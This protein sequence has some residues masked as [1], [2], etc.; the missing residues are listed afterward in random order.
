MQESRVS[1]EGQ[2]QE[3]EDEIKGGNE[4]ICSCSEI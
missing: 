2:A 4:P 3:E 1:R